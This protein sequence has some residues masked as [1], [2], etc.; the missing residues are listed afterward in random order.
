M[1][2]MKARV[3]TAGAGDAGVLVVHLPGGTRMAVADSS[4]ALLAATLL[5]ALGM[6]GA[7][8]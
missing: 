6:G 8:C 2:W 4:Q 7:R 1:R 5:R 3:E